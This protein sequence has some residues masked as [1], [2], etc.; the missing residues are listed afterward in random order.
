MGEKRS[1]YCDSTRFP[2]V[3][4]FLSWVAFTEQDWNGT[5]P[6]KQREFLPRTAFHWNDKRKMTEIPFFPQKTN[7]TKNPNKTKKDQWNSTSLGTYHQVSLSWAPNSKNPKLQHVVLSQAPTLSSKNIQNPEN[8]D[9]WST[10]KEKP[11][12]LIMRQSL[13][14]SFSLSFIQMLIAIL[15]A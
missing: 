5:M 2:N 3:R 6:P 10:K 8:K 12:S 14:T 1:F 7:Q 13:D 9:F 11:S 4:S 15:A